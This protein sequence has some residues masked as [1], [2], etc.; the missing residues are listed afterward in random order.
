MVAKKLGKSQF[1]GEFKIIKTFLT[2][3]GFEEDRMGK[4][5]SIWKHI[6]KNLTTNV[7]TSSSDYRW[8]K[9][10]KSDFCKL[11]TE[12]FTREEIEKLLPKIIKK[13]KM[14]YTADGRLRILRISPKLIFAEPED[15]EEDLLY[16]LLPPDSDDV[17]EKVK[18][19]IQEKKKTILKNTEREKKE[20]LKKLKQRKKEV[21]EE[22]LKEIKKFA[23]EKLKNLQFPPD[24]KI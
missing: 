14:Q 22:I 2:S 16:A 13:R 19:I 9:N 7:T 23:P 15:L 21:E 3:L 4:H 20:K 11:V 10:W 12:N 18:K 5:G 17:Y 24:H 1:K 8:Y 6:E